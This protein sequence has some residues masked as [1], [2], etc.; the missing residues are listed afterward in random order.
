MNIAILILAAG[1]SSRMGV[2]KQLLPVGQSTLLGISIKNA[3]QSNASDTFCVLGANA[4]S[5]KVT[6]LKYN[7]ETIIN[8]NYKL[9]LSSSI[10]SGIK[11]IY[12]K[13][14]DA[15]LIALGDQP[16]VTSQYLNTM[17]EAHKLNTE[18]IIASRYNSTFGVP[19]I[20]PKLYFDQ[21]LQLK[22][23]KGAKDWLNSRKQTIISTE[24]TNLMDIDT[25]KEYQDYLNSIKSE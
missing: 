24:S 25:K 21:L 9:G 18:N 14:Y 7:I 2:A 13:N 17:I 15:V 8:P 10:V 16:L 12:T 3:L 20:I 11:H 19:A 22:G 4:E 6:I 23:D 5:I 1:S